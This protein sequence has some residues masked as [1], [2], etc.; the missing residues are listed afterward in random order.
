MTDINS[1]VAVTINLR[2][3]YPEVQSFGAMFLTDSDEIPVDQGYVT[4]TQTSWNDAN[5]GFDS[6]GVPYAFSQRFFGQEDKADRLLIGRLLQSAIAPAFIMPDYGTDYNVWV[7]GGSGSFGVTDGTN[8]DQV[9]YNPTGSTSWA[10]IVTGLNSALGAVG[11]PTVAGLNT[12]E[13]SVDYLGR[14]RLVMPTAGAS[15]PTISIVAGATGTDYSG[16]LYMSASTG[17]S[18]SGYDAETLSESYSRIKGHTT[19]FGFVMV[20][21]EGSDAE[22]V[23]LSLVINSESRQLVL[24]EDS[25]TAINSGSTADL[26]SL[27]SAQSSGGRTSVMYAQVDGYQDA[28]QVG[29]SLPG[30][31]GATDFM[32]MSLAGTYKSGPAVSDYDLSETN[33]TVLED[34]GYNWIEEI[35]G[36]TYAFDGETV[37]G[38]PMALRLGADWAA[39]DIQTNVLAQRVKLRRLGFDAE[40]IAVYDEVIT[41]TL[42]TL[43]ERRVIQSYEITLPDPDD[44]TDSEKASGTVPLTNAFTAVAVVSGKRFQITG[45]ITL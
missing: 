26:A 5:D 30:P 45:D 9:A 40:S 20:H 39:S 14:L 1:R 32:Y 2:T 29:A 15:E 35:R 12:A 28:A 33:M 25:S 23:A 11:A 8:T 17:Y 24:F 3:R 36:L 4:V 41:N 6:S 31:E 19:D 13:F 42:E 44:F 37:D 27:V 38:T 34:K 7:A 43:L 10:D 21:D 16:D 22:Q 18:V